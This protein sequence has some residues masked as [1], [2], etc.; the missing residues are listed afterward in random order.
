MEPLSSPPKKET[1]KD[2]IYCTSGHCPNIPEIKYS[3]NPLKT[4]FQYKCQCHNNNIYK[5]NLNLKDFLE[6]SSQLYCYGCRKKIPNNKIYFCDTCKNFFEEK[7]VI[8]HE[9]DSHIIFE[10]ENIFKFCIEHKKNFMFRCTE[11]NKSL[12]NDCNLSKCDESGH[13]LMQLR[14]LRPNENNISKIKYIFNK[15]K[16]LFEKIK[17]LNNNLMQTLEN[18]IKIKERCINNYLLK[19]YNSDNNLINLDFN[20]N[21]KYEKILDNI[22]SKNIKDE[23][24]EITTSDYINNYLSILY[25]SLMINKEESLNNSIMN[26]LNKKVNNLVNEE[27]LANHINI[28]QNNN[29]NQIIDIEGNLSNENNSQNLNNINDNNKENKS[30]KKLKSLKAK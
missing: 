3:Y 2:N 7:C 8:E 19:N 15:Q 21:E 11:C 20:N 28:N 9:K 26:E 25:Y 5:P 10:N 1:K 13:H 16:E 27:K 14:S 30:S 29:K 12:C 18:D 24:K 4:E 22:L 23:N 6:K 17:N